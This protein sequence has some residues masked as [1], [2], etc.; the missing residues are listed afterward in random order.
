MK[1]F[2]KNQ[3]ITLIAL[4]ITVIVLLILAGITIATL[5]GNNGILTR[6]QEAKNKTE[7]AQ[8]EE[9]NILNSYEDKINEYA[10]IDWDTVLANAQKHPEQKTSTAIGVG[11]D[12]RPVNMDLWEYTL[13]NDG[14]YALNDEKTLNNIEITSGYKG[15]IE[16]GRI[17]GSVPVYIQDIE[18]DTFIPVTNMSCT[19]L[20]IENLEKS[21]ALPNT[22]I[23][24]Y[25]C[26]CDCTNL[27]TVTNLPDNVTNLQAT[28]AR[29]INLVNAPM[30]P[31]N[32]INMQ[33]TFQ[34]TA[35]YESPNIPNKV[36]N[37]RG[38]FMDC[39]NLKEAPTIPNTVNNMV[40]TF[41]SCDSLTTASEIPYNVIY[42]TYAYA[43][44]PNLCG[45]IEIDANVT[46]S[47]L[48][49]SFGSSAG[50]IDYQN[51]L[52]KSCTIEGLHLQV[53][54]NCQYLEQI[55]NST[56]NSQISL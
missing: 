52:Y 32:V 8:E 4:V 35:I 53:K 28:F 37:M 16:N 36:E 14:T 43:N 7:Q 20:G 51:C 19:F 22:V 5:T 44:C 13:L 15:T 42:I 45:I 25:N 56:M 1:N 47:S 23:D 26:F 48:D 39:N 18:D 27:T 34:S 33:Q 6:A 31:K 2:R 24:L 21:P 46:G 30:I 41:Y 9:Q 12:G 50:L 49:S 40:Q 10:G 11:T 3:G 54:G 38:T 55:V 29:C 17:I